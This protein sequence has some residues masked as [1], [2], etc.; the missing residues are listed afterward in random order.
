MYPRLHEAHSARRTRCWLSFA[1]PFCP[2]RW[3]SLWRPPT[4]WR[5]SVRTHRWLRPLCSADRAHCLST[6]SWAKRSLTPTQ[7]WAVV[8]RSPWPCARHCGAHTSRHTSPWR[9]PQATCRCALSRPP[10][11]RSSPAAISP[12]PGRVLAPS[13]FHRLVGGPRD[14]TTCAIKDFSSYCPRPSATPRLSP[15]ARIP[16]GSARKGTSVVFRARAS[17]MGAPQW[18]PLSGAF[19]HQPEVQVHRPSS[20]AHLRP[21]VVAPPVKGT[22]AGTRRTD[23]LLAATGACQ[24]GARPSRRCSFTSRTSSP[25]SALLLATLPPRSDHSTLFVSVAGIWT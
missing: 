9:R 13:L 19:S 12:S 18:S 8:R 11:F 21:P 4:H 14:T 10:A 7:V 17:S 24:H 3:P 6:A 2:F 15:T 1:P 5:H 16:R 20:L 22:V 23:A 25:S